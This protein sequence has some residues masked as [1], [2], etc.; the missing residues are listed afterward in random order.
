[1]IAGFDSYGFMKLH[2]R[3]RQFS[4]PDF[5]PWSNGWDPLI[6]YSVQLDPTFEW[7]Y[8]PALEPYDGQEVIDPKPAPCM[9]LCR[10]AI[11]QLQNYFDM[12]D[13]AQLME[14]SGYSRHLI[15]STASQILRKSGYKNFRKGPNESLFYKEL[16]WDI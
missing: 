11:N 8:Q 16:D 15:S 1:M 5:M 9:T 10:E 7:G 3:F 4:E 14:G 12:D 2:P 6:D 13:I